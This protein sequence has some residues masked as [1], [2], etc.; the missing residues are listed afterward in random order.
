MGYD[1]PENRIGDPEEVNGAE[2][3]HL[4]DSPRSIANPLCEVDGNYE[5]VDLLTEG[6]DG[7][8]YDKN[9]NEYI[10]DFLPTN[11]RGMDVYRLKRTG[12]DLRIRKTLLAKGRPMS[13][14]ELDERVRSIVGDRRIY[15]KVPGYWDELEKFRA[16]NPLFSEEELRPLVNGWARERREEM[17]AAEAAMKKKG[18][19][20]NSKRV[21]KK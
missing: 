16:A 2:Q 5:D 20:R 11:G 3:L 7:H 18:R 13:E 1:S 4:I 10:K 21:E 12:E 6:S 14:G 9:G 8:W 15:E 17:R 19:N